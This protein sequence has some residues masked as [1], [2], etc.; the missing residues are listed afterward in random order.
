MRRRI[1]WFKVSKC[2]FSVSVLHHSQNPCEHTN[3]VR[4]FAHT[5]APYNPYNR[6]QTIPYTMQ[7]CDKL[8]AAQQKSWV[9]IDFGQQ[10]NFSAMVG[11]PAELPWWPTPGKWRILEVANRLIN[12]SFSGFSFSD[13]PIFPVYHCLQLLAT[14]QTNNNRLG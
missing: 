2:W 10:E 9:Q 5:F 12:G 6:Q 4:L 7:Q 14:S 1:R 3:K 11:R 8:Y 13:L